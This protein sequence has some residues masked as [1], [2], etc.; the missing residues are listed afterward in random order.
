MVL[1]VYGV[2]LLAGALL[3][4]IAQRS[5]LSTSVL[6]LVVGYVVGPGGLRIIDVT[7]SA[8]FVEQLTELFVSSAEREVALTAFVEHYNDERPHL[9][10]D[11]QT[12]RQRLAVKLAA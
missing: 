4:A 12:P 6:F 3:S 1:P 11:G 9:G 8:P 2:T 5:I 10:I 7:P